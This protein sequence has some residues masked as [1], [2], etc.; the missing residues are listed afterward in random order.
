MDESDSKIKVSSF[1]ER[2]DSIDKVANS[3]LSKSK[4]NFDIIN[5]QKALINS[6]NVSIEALETKVRDIANFII[7]EKKLEKDAEE[8]RLFEQQDESQKGSMLERLAGLKSNNE[9]EQTQAA[10][11]EPKKGGG[12][13]LGTLLTL[14]IGA[15]A[16][17]F[18]WPAI[19][20]A[21]GG[22]L[23]GALAKF[24]MFSIGGIGSLIKSIIVATG[25]TGIG[26]FG[27]GKMF[28][29][30]GDSAENRGNKVAE[31]ASNAI[32]NF[33]FN[34]DGK[35]DGPNK[36]EVGGGEG[37]GEEGGEEGGERDFG[38][39]YKKKE[40]DAFKAAE[41]YKAEKSNLN[42]EKNSAVNDMNKTLE[43]KDLKKKDR[44]KITYTKEEVLKMVEEYKRLV[45]KEVAASQ[46][47]GDELTHNEQFDMKKLQIELDKIG[48]ETRYGE[49]QGS[50]EQFNQ[51]I[52]DYDKKVGGTGVKE[53]PKYGDV[54]GL[55]KT[56]EPKIENKDLD[57]GMSDT[58]SDKFQSLNEQ[59][60]MLSEDLT[61]TINTESGQMFSRPAN[62]PNTTV[63]VFKQTASNTPFTNMMKNNYLSLNKTQQAK[64]LR[65]MK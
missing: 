50:V 31:S 29:K 17:K 49:I 57:L 64:L 11:E 30:F 24:A 18:L 20:P 12:G 35:V 40:E 16:L 5:N 19:L 45:K 41:A 34:E 8:D 58:F 14:G 6:I 53:A 46:G 21:V 44:K 27:I 10:G 15:F 36:L 51:A 38:D 55:I 43:K 32:K 37:G 25:L 13:I 54:G 23:K 65:Y 22:L 3:A 59:V 2:V 4:G 48:I 56:V 52:E 1:F 39:D 42:I 28:Q 61:G 60:D 63:T 7:I 47:S 33:K 62:S 9:S 26:V